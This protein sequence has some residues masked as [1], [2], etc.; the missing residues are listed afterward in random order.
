MAADLNDLNELKRHHHAR[1]AP[2]DARSLA[3]TRY[4]ATRMPFNA[5]RAWPAAVAVLCAVLFIPA[6]L[7]ED[8]P[9][10]EPGYG[11][12]GLSLSQMDLPS[13]FNWQT[14]TGLSPSALSVTTN[15]PLG[16]PNLSQLSVTRI[17]DK[18]TI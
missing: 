15:L 7:R 8:D 4:L 11:A 14:T 12:A 18:E 17:E 3:V 10:S 9:V 2:V 5:W 1:R 13:R 6:A 16:V